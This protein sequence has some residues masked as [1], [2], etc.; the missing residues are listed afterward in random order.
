MVFNADNV[1]CIL[2]EFLLNKLVELSIVFDFSINPF[3]FLRINMIRK[4]Q[5]YF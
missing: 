1:K 4:C 5:W 3:V 2:F